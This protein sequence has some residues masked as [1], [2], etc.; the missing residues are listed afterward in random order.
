VLTPWSRSSSAEA[1]ALKTPTRPITERHNVPV[2]GNW[3]VVFMKFIE[4][5]TPKYDLMITMWVLGVFGSAV[6]N[7]SQLIQP[8]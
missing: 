3:P 1:A 8:Q 5:I 2:Q 6:F 7:R 4:E